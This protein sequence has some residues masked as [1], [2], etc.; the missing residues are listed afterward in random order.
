M[1]NGKTEKKER[2]REKKYMQYN[3]SIFNKK[4]NEAYCCP[5]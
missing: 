5:P 2:E 1:S 4:L 3:S